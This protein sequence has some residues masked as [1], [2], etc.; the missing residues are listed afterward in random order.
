MWL[1]AHVSAAHYLAGT[2]LE[3]ASWLSVTPF[4]P[5]NIITFVL[6]DSLSSLCETFH[7]FY[8]ATGSL[9]QPPTHFHPYCPLRG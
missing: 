8:L 3:G 1:T 6:P 9:S 2:A 4:H 5:D 7:P